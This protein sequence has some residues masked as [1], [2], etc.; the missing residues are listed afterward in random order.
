[1]SASVQLRN[2]VQAIQVRATDT[3]VNDGINLLA[4]VALPLAAANLLAELLH[5]VENLVDA[6]NDAHTVNLHG[7]VRG[8]TEGNMVDGTVLS[9][10]DLLAGEHV[11]AKLLE[12][13]LF[14]KLDQEL[15]GF[16]S[17]KV[18]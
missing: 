11:I 12:A 5:V 3:N 2:T 13:S 16:L 15:D 14:S 1:M 18:L 7:L 6:L 8:I 10:V 4:S 9:E 17:D